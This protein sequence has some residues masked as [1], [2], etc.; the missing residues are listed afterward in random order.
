MLD[1]HPDRAQLIAWLRQNGG[2]V[3]TEYLDKIERDSQGHARA[4]A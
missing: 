1:A 2:S 3:W 4:K